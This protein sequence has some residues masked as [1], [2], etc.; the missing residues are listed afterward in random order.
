MIGSVSG[1]GGDP[2]ALGVLVE[3]FRREMRYPRQ[4]D[5]E[6]AAGR[7]DLLPILSRGELETAIAAPPLRMP[8]S[9]GGSR[10]TRTAD[11]GI[12]S[13]STCT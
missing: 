8:L 3:R 2:D 10:P 11:L 4:E 13:R 1:A 7:R 12:R 9:S 6:Y 5:Y